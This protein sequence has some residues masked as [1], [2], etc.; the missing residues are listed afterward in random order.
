VSLDPA[1]DTPERMKAFAARFKARPGWTWL[2]GAPGDVE[3]ALRGLGAYTASFADHPPMILVGDG[4]TGTWSR[5][6]GFPRQ[7]Q[8]LAKVDEL[9]AARGALARKE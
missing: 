9:A 2:T 1:R 8:V 6:N 5:F 4:K 7:D 3:Q